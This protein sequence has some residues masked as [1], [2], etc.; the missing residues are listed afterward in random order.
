LTW[1]N[2]NGEA[3]GCPIMA[4]HT[5][6]LLFPSNMLHAVLDKTMGHLMK[7]QHLLVNPKY[8]ELWGKSYTKE[9]GR[10]AQGI[11]RVSNGTDTIIFICHKDIPHD[12]KCDICMHESV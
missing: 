9:L 5:A 6:L 3:T 7:M 10:L 1:I 8:T 12:R 2:N 4:R 11:P